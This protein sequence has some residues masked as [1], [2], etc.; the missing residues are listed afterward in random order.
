MLLH[1]NRLFELHFLWSLNSQFLWVHMKKVKISGKQAHPWTTGSKRSLKSTNRRLM[2]SPGKR[3]GIH[4]DTAISLHIRAPQNRWGGRGGAYFRPTQNTNICL[5]F[6]FLGGG[7]TPDQLKLK[8]PRSAQIFIVGG[9][10][11]GIPDQH[12]WNTWLMA[13]REFWTK[14][15]GNWNVSGITDSLSHTTYVET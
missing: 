3:D 14:I 11:G 6:N 9:G 15:S 4:G 13:L 12:F 8:V 1:W 5:N 7:C 10:R 2:V